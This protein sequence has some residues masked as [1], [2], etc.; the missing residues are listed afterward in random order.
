MNGGVSETAHFILNDS[1]LDSLKNCKSL[2]I[3]FYRNP[4]SISEEGI[5]AIKNHIN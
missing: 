3:K 5:I 1:I 4:L 2:T